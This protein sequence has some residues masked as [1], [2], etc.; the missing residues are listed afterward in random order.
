MTKTA[1]VLFDLDVPLKEVNGPLHRFSTSRFRQGIPIP[2]AATP[3]TS[4]AS[5]Q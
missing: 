2:A 5:S 3:G 4:S 1:A